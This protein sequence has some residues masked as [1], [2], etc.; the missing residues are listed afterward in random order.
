M[1]FTPAA[2]N[3]PQ[4]VVLMHE[5][6]GPGVIMGMHNLEKSIRSLRTRLH[7]LRASTRKCDLWFGAKDTIA[8]MYHAFLKEIFRREAEARK[9]RL[10]AGRDRI[11]LHADRRCGGADRCRPKAACSGRCMNYDGD[12]M[13]DM[14]AS[15]FGSLGLMTSVL[16][17]PEG[18]TCTRP[19]T[20]P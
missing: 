5:F 9:K 18:N 2:G 8:K 16:V 7:H 3:G 15:G 20:A 11:P 12:V 10:R 17:S 6:K 1:V 19:R 13:S 4:I 14:V